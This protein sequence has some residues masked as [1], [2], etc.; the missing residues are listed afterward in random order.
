VSLVFLYK[1]YR[2]RMDYDLK[3]ILLNRH[4]NV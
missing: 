4:L 3:K 2:Y 1:D